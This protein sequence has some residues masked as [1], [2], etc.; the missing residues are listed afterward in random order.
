MK[1]AIARAK[2]CA[3]RGVAAEQWLVVL[4]IQKTEGGVNSEAEIAVFQDEGDAT[5]V[6]ALCD[7]PRLL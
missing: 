5:A 3:T 6:A 4:K 2:S 7:R 1:G